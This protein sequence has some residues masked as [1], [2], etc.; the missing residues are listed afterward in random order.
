M[1]K[2]S[3]PIPMDEMKRDILRPKLSTMKKTKIAVAMT[4]T[5]P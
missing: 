3:T 2:N 1:M 4:L 5:I